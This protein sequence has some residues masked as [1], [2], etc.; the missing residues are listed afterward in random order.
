MGSERVSGKFY[1]IQKK[2]DFKVGEKT[3]IRYEGIV[4]TISC[5]MGQVAR[6]KRIKPF[7]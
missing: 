6:G 2:A 1:K 7:M 5:Q 4:L 3:L